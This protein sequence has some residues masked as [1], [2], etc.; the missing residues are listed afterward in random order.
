V[1]GRARLLSRWTI[2]GIVVSVA[3]VGLS[4]AYPPWRPG[5]PSPTPQGNDARADQRTAP[6]T[7]TSLTD[8]LRPPTIPHIAGPEGVVETRLR[9]HL[10][11]LHWVDAADVYVERPEPDPFAREPRPTRVLI[12]VRRAPGAKITQPDVQAVAR[13]VSWL[14]SD[15]AG[16]PDLLIADSDGSLLYEDGKLSLPAAAP[17]VAQPAET[18]RAAEGYL[19]GALIGGALVAAAI[20]IAYLVWRW[21]HGPRPPAEV[22]APS[23]RSLSGLSQ[24]KAASLA[25][26]LAREPD[27]VRALVLQGLD[28]AQARELR[29][30]LAQSGVTAD[31]PPRDVALT[32][33]VWG[34]VEEA[35]SGG[36]ETTRG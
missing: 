14:A 34:V 31:V 28:E 4:I 5:T 9:S 20:A 36:A 7:R 24:M 10:A 6:S 15:T 29:E 25:E 18:R 16:D 11:L 30:K 27:Y 32:P 23:T 8:L 33:Q 12:T 35:L 22:A 2:V 26:Q 3:V 21:L 19:T 13:L 17:P 1:A